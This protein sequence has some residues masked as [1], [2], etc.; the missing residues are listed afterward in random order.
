MGWCASL[1]PPPDEVQGAQDAPAAPVTAQ[2]PV[3]TPPPPAASEPA[4]APTE[5]E[6][7]YPAEQ[8]ANVKKMVGTALEL[9]Y[10]K[11]IECDVNRTYVIPLFWNSLDVDAKRGF[12]VSVAVLCELEGRP[13]MIDVYDQQSGKRL[14]AYSNGRHS[15]Y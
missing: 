4:P 3:E 5:P 2:A 15:F 9:G 13:A 11:R 14:A 1:A 10:I 8:I 6:S 12:M 7:Q